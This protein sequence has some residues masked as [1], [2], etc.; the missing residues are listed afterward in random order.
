MRLSWCGSRSRLAAAAN[1]VEHL[2]FRPRDDDS[3]HVVAALARSPWR[4]PAGNRTTAR[5]RS[6]GSRLR[7]FRPPSQGFASV[8]DGRSLA[9]YSCGGSRGPFTR[10]PF[11]P[12]REPRA[13]LNANS[14]AAGPS[15]GRERKGGAGESNI[16]CATESL[17]RSPQCGFHALAASGTI[18]RIRPPPG[19]GSKRQE[20]HVHGAGNRP[21]DPRKADLSSHQQAQNSPNRVLRTWLGDTMRQLRLSTET[22]DRAEKHDYDV[23][24]ENEIARHRSGR[25]GRDSVSLVVH[26]QARRG[27]AGFHF[28]W[29]P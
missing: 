19:G 28:V 18:R 24:Q 11:H 20:S 5:G 16:I 10:V 17:E 23:P 21:P 15:N 27:G 6:P 13:D 1:W 29:C 3:A 2:H 8:A 7:R 9:G 25:S 26:N 14:R 22:L 4:T 12:S